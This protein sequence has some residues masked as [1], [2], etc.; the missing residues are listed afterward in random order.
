MSKVQPSVHSEPPTRASVPDESM[1]HSCTPRT[2]GHRF[3]A[4]GYRPVSLSPMSITRVGIVGS[5]IMGSGIAE[6][7]AAAG[8]EVVLRSR[9][10]AR[11]GRHGGRPRQVTGQAGRE[12]EAHR[13]GGGRDLGPR[14]RH[15]APRRP[16]RRRSGDR[17]GRRGP[18]REEGALRRA[19]QRLQARDHPGDEHVHAAGGR[20]GHGDGPAGPGLRRPLLQSGAGHG[21]RRDRAPRHRCGRHGRGGHERS[22]RPAARIPS[23]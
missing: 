4:G 12:G 20:D 11:R 1:A 7:A 3:D 17:V 23:R 19:R 2:A 13:G 21:A 22:R 6:V 5:G 9:S 15:G 18:G 8:H 14:A 16:R 10:R